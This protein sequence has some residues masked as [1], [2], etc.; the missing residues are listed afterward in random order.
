MDSLSHCY[1]MNHRI[2]DSSDFDVSSPRMWG[3]I[4]TRE[5][6]DVSP[7][8]NMQEEVSCKMMWTYHRRGNKEL[9]FCRTKMSESIIAWII[10]ELKKSQYDPSFCL[11]FCSFVLFFKNRVEG[12]KGN[13][14]MLDCWFQF[15]CGGRAKR[16][17]KH[18]RLLV[19]IH[20]RW[21]GMCFQF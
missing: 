8:K 15:T 10:I 2:L 9:S 17:W 14:N 13:W 4:R 12:Q 18:A 6:S 11:F 21:Y 16:Q 1:L 5:L 7:M 19:S 3:V 20:L